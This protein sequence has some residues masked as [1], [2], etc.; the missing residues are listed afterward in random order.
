[1]SSKKCS[2]LWVTAYGISNPASFSVA[3][4]QYKIDK[5]AAEDKEEKKLAKVRVMTSLPYWH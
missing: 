5:K 4:D 1:M 2:A 3:K